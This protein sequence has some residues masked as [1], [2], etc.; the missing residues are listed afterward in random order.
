MSFSARE[1]LKP[2]PVDKFAQH[3]QRMHA[4]RDRQFELEY[5][6]SICM[7]QDSENTHKKCY[8]SRVPI[9]GL[10]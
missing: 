8:N 9:S 7:E 3:V 2:I 5:N 10:C 6:V 1:R 4:D